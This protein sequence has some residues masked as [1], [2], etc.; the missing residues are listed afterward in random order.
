MRAGPSPV[1]PLAALLGVIVAVV[2]LST[3]VAEAGGLKTVPGSSERSG[4]GKLYRYQ[5][6][7]ERGIPY[8]GAEFAREVHGIL[9]HRR[10]WGRRGQVAFKRVSRRAGTEIVLA[11]PR[12]VDRLCRP[13]PTNGQYSCQV[14]HRVILNWRRWMKGVPHWTSTRTNYRRMLVNHEVGHRLGLG[15]RS[16]RRPGKRAAVMQQQSIGLQGCRAS[17]WPK[18]REYRRLPG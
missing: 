6:K 13:I 11:T 2:V 10:G 1:R 9:A 8:S 17:W 18:R 4:P 12:K 16:C 3:D 15:H 14:G 7:V 5:L